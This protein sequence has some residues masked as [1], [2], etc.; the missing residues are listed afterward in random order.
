MAIL[1]P[2]RPGRAALVGTGLIGGSIG[3]ALRRRGWHVTG[4]DRD[5]AVAERALEL[6]RA[7]RGRHRS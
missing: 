4:C 7:R 2:G 3:M 5:P 1:G 6:A